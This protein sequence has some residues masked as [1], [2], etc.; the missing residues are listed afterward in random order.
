M[1]AGEDLINL[2]EWLK[3]AS[4]DR[5]AGLLKALTQ[6]PLPRKVPVEGRELC[7]W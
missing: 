4:I 5:E 7:I 3:A 1:C 6:V 2:V